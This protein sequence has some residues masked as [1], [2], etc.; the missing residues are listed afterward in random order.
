VRAERRALAIDGVLG[1]AD[2]GGKADAVLGA[3]DVVVH[4][5]GN[6]NQFDALVGQNLAE[7]EG[8]VAADRDQVVEAELL[9]VLEDDGREVVDAV[10]DLELLEAV[11]TD[12]GGSLPAFILRA[13]VRE[14]WS[15]VRRCDRSRGCCCDRAGR[16]NPRPGRSPASCGSGLPAAPDAVDLIPKLGCAIDDAFDDGVQTGDVAA[17]GQ[18]ADY[19]GF[20]SCV[21]SVDVRAQ[22][23]C[24]A[25]LDGRRHLKAPAGN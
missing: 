25:F 20:D 16:C 19:A 3:L 2:C 21:P 13:L 8:I 23:K 12:V 15:Q 1:P 18:D 17:A 9:D 24:A 6:R 4:R 7:A 10:L 5:L 14:V 22:P 11:R